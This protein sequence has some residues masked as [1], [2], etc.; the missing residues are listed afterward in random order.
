M[1]ITI[2]ARKCK[3]TREY[4]G[5]FK[6]AAA[7]TSDGISFLPPTDAWAITSN[8]YKF[9]FFNILGRKVKNRKSRDVLIFSRR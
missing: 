1:Y 8:I 7:I 4:N 2:S 9:S 6:F 3:R 5:Y